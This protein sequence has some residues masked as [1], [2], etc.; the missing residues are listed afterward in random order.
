MQICQKHYDA[1]KTAIQDFGLD[2]LVSKTS[3]E[4]HS[5][6][7]SSLE[8]A[9]MKA[10]FDPLMY[11]NNAIFSQVLNVSAAKGYGLEV[12]FVT[13]EGEHHCPLC[14]LNTKHSEAC[15]EPNCEFTYDNWVDRAA[16]DALA[17]AIHLGLVGSS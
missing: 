10:S 11:A 3:E 9:N 13:P 6:M 16:Q 14:F 15:P 5:K 8:E 2:R 17:T 1:L 7:V 4:A 12:M